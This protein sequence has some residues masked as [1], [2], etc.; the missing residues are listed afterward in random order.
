MSLEK[1]IGFTSLGELLWWLNDLAQAD[2]AQ[3]V[4]WW[5][6]EGEHPYLVKATQELTRAAEQSEGELRRPIV[7]LKA[8]PRSENSSPLD[9]LWRYAKPY[10]S[11]RARSPSYWLFMIES[12]RE[13]TYRTLS[14][15]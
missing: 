12:M 5:I 4:M 2:L 15:T 8:P 11:K 10:K 14:T 13:E 9:Q 1:Y 6:V 7:R 3:C